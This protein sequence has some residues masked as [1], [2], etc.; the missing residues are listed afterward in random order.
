MKRNF[1]KPFLVLFLVGMLGVLSTIFMII[2]QI[3]GL[4]ASMPELA[5]LP[6][7]VIVAISLAQLTLLLAIAV[8]VGC[9]LAPR[10]GLRSYIAEKAATG[11]AILSRLT[12]QLPLAIISG[13]LLAFLIMALDMVFITAIA[14]ELQDI[15]TTQIHPAEQLVI[16]MLYGGITEELLLRW[17]FMTFLVWLGWRFLQRSQGIPSAPVAWGAIILAAILFGIAHLPAMAAVIPLTAGIITRTVLLNALGGVLFGWLFWRHSLE[18]AMV[19]HATIHVGFALIGLL[20]G[21][22]IAV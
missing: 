17:G 13:L 15:G 8:A 7:F 21:G 3:A 19:A 11:T 12:P 2:P 14:Q 22:S 20:A 18:A 10:V 16:G 6:D 5:H 1:W 9:I 4:I